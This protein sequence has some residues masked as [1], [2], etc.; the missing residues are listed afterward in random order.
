M[1]AVRVLGL[2]GMSLPILRELVELDLMPEAGRFLETCTALPLRS[3]IPFSTVPGWASIFTGV[4][5]GDHGLL[6]WKREDPWLP[7]SEPRRKGFTSYHDS[8]QPP[9]WE[10]MNLMEYETAF[11]DIPAS[12]PAPTT[13]GLFVSGFLGPWP[14]P[15]AVNPTELRPSTSNWLESDGGIGSSS[16]RPVTELCRAIDALSE[17]THQRLALYSSTF[18]ESCQLTF[19]V[20][21]GPD[22]LSHVTWENLIPRPEGPHEITRSVSRYWRF[23]DEFFVGLNQARA[24]GETAIVCSDHGSTSPPQ[25]RFQ[26]LPWLVE[27]GYA[28]APRSNA[29]AN[30]ARGLGAGLDGIRRGLRP[31]VQKLGIQNSARRL[32][33]Q[34]R[35]LIWEAAQ[36]DHG[37][38]MIFPTVLGDHE[39]GF[40]I[41]PMALDKARMAKELASQLRQELHEGTSI[42]NEVGPAH[43][44]IGPVRSSD[45]VPDVWGVTREDIG[46]A[47]SLTQ[48]RVLTE[49]TNL[50][51]GVHHR[52][53][54]LL[55]GSDHTLVV[56]EPAVED[57]TPSSPRGFWMLRLPIGCTE[58]RSLTSLR[59]N[60]FQGM[61]N[62]APP[63]NHNFRGRRRRQ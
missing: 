60:C 7:W 59:P 39:A 2:D 62:L 58:A 27:K 37:E 55:L 6:W 35:S 8:P 51:R 21:V 13:K 30:V 22:R 32:R 19:Q 57:I 16:D 31:V 36:S 10:L 17:A 41:N 25:L 43:Q 61:L 33:D 56:Q 14:H 49:E 52:F 54:L 20:L 15:R 24:R 45:R 11:V 12:F 53:G 1:N 9:L 29:A 46:V 34:A 42:F 5:P 63:R 3:T 4:L 28:P 23:V 18:R 48:G 47:A 26:L 40:F 44:F 38:A 50:S